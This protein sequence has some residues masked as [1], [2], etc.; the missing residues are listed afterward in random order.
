MTHNDPGWLCMARDDIPGVR[1]VPGG[2]G[3]HQ[4]APGATRLLL[5]P[6]WVIKQQ[7][8][9]SKPWLKVPK[10]C[11]DP[12]RMVS[13]HFW[14]IWGHLGALQQR[15]LVKMQY[16][17]KPGR[18]NEITGPLPQ[19]TRSNFLKVSQ[20]STHVN[21]SGMCG[22]LPKNLILWENLALEAGPFLII[23]FRISDFFS[24]K[25]VKNT[26]KITTLPKKLKITSPLPIFWYMSFPENLNLGK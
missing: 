26:K 24:R 1:G 18:R 2:P 7:N 10:V 12:K 21:M 22:K 4:G 20:F 17:Q 3:G 23:F 13:I 14:C 8:N 11:P 9:G 19:T 25:I 5:T 6:K 16:C 15:Y